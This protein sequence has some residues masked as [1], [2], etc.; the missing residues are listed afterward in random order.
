M[1]KPVGERKRWGTTDKKKRGDRGK[2][3]AESPQRE[4]TRGCFRGSS[5]WIIVYLCLFICVCC[6]K[7]WHTFWFAQLTE[8]NWSRS[9]AC[10]CKTSVSCPFVNFSHFSSVGPSAGP[11]HY[12]RENVSNKCLKHHLFPWIACPGYCV[13]HLAVICMAIIFSKCQR[14]KSCTVNTSDLLFVLHN[15][16]CQ[17]T[18]RFLPKQH[19]TNKLTCKHVFHLF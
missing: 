5:V 4:E 10:R 17:R 15:P 13:N 6:T 18:I 2:R 1:L 3:S 16:C 7:Y 9:K 8:L 11:Q 12:F 19:N 14:K